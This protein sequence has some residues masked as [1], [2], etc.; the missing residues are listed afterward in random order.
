MTASTAEFRQV[1]D[2][3]PGAP[4]PDGS[5]ADALA[6]L[7]HRLR[8]DGGRRG[9]DRG[10]RLSARH[11][12]QRNRGDAQFPRHRVRQPGRDG[13]LHGERICRLRRRRDVVADRQSH[14][15]RKSAAHVRQAAAR[16]HRLLRRPPFVRIH[17]PAHHRRRRRQPGDQSSDHRHRP[18]SDVADRAVHR[19]GGSGSGDVA[20]R[21][22]S[23]RRRRSCSCASSFAGCV[24]SPA[25]NSP[26]AR[27]SSRPCRKRCKACAWSRPSRSKTRCGAGSPSASVRSRAR[28]QQD[29]ARR[30][31]RQSA[32]GN[33]RRL[34]HRAGVDL[35]RLPRHLYRRDARR[36]RLLPGGVPARL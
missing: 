11:H 35:R 25:C 8:A 13:H 9:G 19:D 6:A 36:I 34:R 20:R 10:H 24:A 17:R 16:K 29:G 1:F 23:S 28:I 21:T 5:G 27:G 33:A 26:A 31:P 32:D 4:P 22:S 15:R 18:R 14:R 12:D 3:H 2:R 7:R 30:Q